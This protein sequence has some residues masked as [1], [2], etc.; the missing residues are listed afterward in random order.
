M[1]AIFTLTFSLVFFISFGQNFTLN[2]KTKKY[3]Q[4][5]EMTFENTS[6][7]KIFKV[8]SKWIKDSYKG[9]RHEVKKKNIESGVLK[10]KGNYKTNVL[11]KKG[12][13]EHKITFHI[14]DNKISYTITNF[15][16]FSTKSGR[17]KFE[18]KKL[19]KKRKMIQETK[20]NI[21]EKMS[22]L[23]VLLNKV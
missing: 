20:K 4:K 12:M 1:K 7:E 17:I 23:K 22:S 21:T 5:G 16:Y 3:E 15:E 14:T 2:P 9:L 18:E 10:V 8:A 19:P 11:I 13:I 6:K